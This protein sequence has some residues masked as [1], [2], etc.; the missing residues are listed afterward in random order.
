MDANVAS[1][2]AVI[3]WF[4]SV[5]D[6]AQLQFKVD[7]AKAFI[8]SLGLLVIS[9]CHNLGGMHLS[10]C[11]IDVSLD[12]HGAVHNLATAFQ[13]LHKSVG[14]VCKDLWSHMKSDGL[15]TSDF[16]SPQ[17]P[18]LDVLTFITMFFRYRRLR[19]KNRCQ[20][21]MLAS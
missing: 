5:I 21:I 7:M 10:F 1:S 20:V 4:M 2:A 16:D 6:L 9:Q 11:D 12:S 13:A 14:Q 8:K 17:L 15:V 3:A 19:K 18:F